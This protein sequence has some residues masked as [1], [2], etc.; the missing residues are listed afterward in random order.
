MSNQKSEGSTKLRDLIKGI[1]NCKTAAEE[2][3]LVQKEKAL[4]RESF[5]VLFG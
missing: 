4:I 5:R 1:R 2:R 3:A